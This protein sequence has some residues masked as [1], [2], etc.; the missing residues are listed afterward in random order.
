METHE[1]QI[2]F[3][4]I[5]SGN[6]CLLSCHLHCIYEIADT[7]GEKF[8]LGFIFVSHFFNTWI[9]FC[10]VTGPLLIDSVPIVKM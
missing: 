4:K 10:E 3:V 7:L 2:Y 5:G 9:Y 6:V 8:L 1:V